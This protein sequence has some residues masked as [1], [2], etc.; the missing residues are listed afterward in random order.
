MTTPTSPAPFVSTLPVEVGLDALPAEM[1]AG[2]GDDDTRSLAL[3]VRDLTPHAPNRYV[4]YNFQL[5]PPPGNR[6]L[7]Q[8]PTTLRSSN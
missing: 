6:H 3:K 8:W 2:D 7:S 1:L 4:I 5:T